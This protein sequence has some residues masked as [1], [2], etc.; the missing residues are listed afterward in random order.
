MEW[1]QSIIQLICSI[2]YHLI[3]SFLVTIMSLAIPWSCSLAVVDLY[4]ICVRCHFQYPGLMIIIA[5]GD[6][7]VMNYDN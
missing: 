3:C 2:Q 7:V 1:N 4:A 5:I 6:W